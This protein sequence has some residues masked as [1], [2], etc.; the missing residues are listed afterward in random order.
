MHIPWEM[1]SLARVK[2]RFSDASNISVVIN[3][4]LQNQVKFHANLLTWDGNRQKKCILVPSIVQR[5][6]ET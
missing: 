1:L 6:V 5:H 4:R 3:V 2:G